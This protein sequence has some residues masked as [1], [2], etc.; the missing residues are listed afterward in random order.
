[1][2]RTTWISSYAFILEHPLDRRTGTS[3][4]D[5]DIDP[6]F[7][8]P[9]PIPEH[10]SSRELAQLPPLLVIGRLIHMDHLPRHGIR[11]N[12]KHPMAPAVATA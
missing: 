11:D 3:F 2:D 10:P 4:L 5:D 7:T 6:L 1:M 9:P 12:A 8:P